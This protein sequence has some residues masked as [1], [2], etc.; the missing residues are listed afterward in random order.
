MVVDDRAETIS[1]LFSMELPINGD[2][3]QHMMVGMMDPQRKEQGDAT[4]G[5]N[6]NQTSSFKLK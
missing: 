6:P 3:D 2:F 4:R 1:G 5:K